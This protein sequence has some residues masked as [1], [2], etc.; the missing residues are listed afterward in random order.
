MDVRNDIQAALDDLTGPLVR[1]L[2]AGLVLADL[3][4]LATIIIID[5]RVEPSNLRAVG[6]GVPILGGL[7]LSLMGALGDGLR[8]TWMR[9]QDRPAASEE[10]LGQR[11]RVAMRALLLTGVWVGLLLI[12]PQLIVLA[13]G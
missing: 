4:V 8:A 3:A 7:A 11:R 12:G 6:I 10:R 2:L 13:S 1:W 5:Q 9:L